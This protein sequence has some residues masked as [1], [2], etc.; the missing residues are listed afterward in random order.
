MVNAIVMGWLVFV[1]FFSSFLLSCIYFNFSSSV[2]INTK[3][4]QS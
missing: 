3:M 2:M 1:L 4:L